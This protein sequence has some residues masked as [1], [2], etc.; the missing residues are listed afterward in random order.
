M[1]I[2]HLYLEEGIVSPLLFV[3]FHCRKFLIGRHEGRS[4][5]MGEEQC[6][7]AKMEQLN[8]VVM[9][10]NSASTG[11]RDLLCRKHLPMVVRIVMRVASYL[12]A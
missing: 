6:L 3:G 10:D 7:G 1:R 2:V 8:H 12:L 4:H 5:V 11:I 9:S